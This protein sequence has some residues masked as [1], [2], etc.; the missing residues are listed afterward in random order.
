[1]CLVSDFKL[2]QI[3]HAP[4]PVRAHATGPRRVGRRCSPN[5]LGVPKV[6]IPP[7]FLLL[8]L[9]DRSFSRYVFTPKS[10]P[11]APVACCFHDLFCFRS[12]STVLFL[13]PMMYQLTPLQVLFVCVP[14]AFP[15]FVL[16]LHLES[17]LLLLQSQPVLVWWAIISP[18]LYSILLMF[19]RLRIVLL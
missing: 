12:L 7:F 5:M 10:L 11:F 4:A 13:L 17:Q 6:G 1:M 16:F 14:F 9:L 18:L 19:A 15:P 2:D 8:L 3:P